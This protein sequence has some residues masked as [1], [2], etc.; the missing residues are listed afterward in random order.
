MGDKLMT[1]YSAFI[2]T[3][4]FLMDDLNKRGYTESQVTE[5]IGV[6]LLDALRVG[7]LCGEKTTSQAAAKEC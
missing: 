6:F 1:D 2:D 7:K 3:V 4:G 5:I